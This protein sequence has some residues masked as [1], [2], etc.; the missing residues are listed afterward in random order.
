MKQDNETQHNAREILASARAF[1]KRG[2]TQGALARDWH[3]MK[4][5]AIDEDEACAWCVA[6][7]LDAGT[8]ELFGRLD[9]AGVPLAELTLREV[10]FPDQPASHH[11]SDWNDA[12]ERKKEEVLAAFDDGIGRLTKRQEKT[13]DSA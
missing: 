9:H 5:S 8:Y 7:A 2:W 4:C 12:P 1:I 10:V 3:G 13:H 6:G 11:L